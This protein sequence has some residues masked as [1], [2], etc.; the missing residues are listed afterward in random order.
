MSSKL[1]FQL[2]NPTGMINQVMSLE[3]AVGLSHETKKETIVHYISNQG[4]NLYNFKTVP[5][6]TPSRWYNEQRKGFTDNDQFP[7]I[8]DILE[9]D[10][11]I[12]LIDEKISKFP[13]EEL[14]ID[15]LITEGYFSKEDTISADEEQ[16]A[17]GRQRLDVTKNLHLK[18]TLGWY[19]RFFFNRSQSLDQ[20]LSSVKFKKE[21]FDFAE[22][23][24]KSIGEFQ[25]GHIRLSDHLHMFNTTQ[26]M[27]EAG[28]AELEQNRLPIVISTCDPNNAMIQKNKHRFILLDEYIVNNFSKEFLSL[29]FKDEVVFG[30]ICNIVM[31][32]AKY[33]IGTSGSTYTAYIQRQRNQNNEI[34]NWSFWDKPS[35]YYDGPFSWNNYNLENGRKM[36]WREWRESKL[37]I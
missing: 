10:A 16:F 24:C 32:K 35:D 37:N 34:E 22:M 36:W 11:D 28:L 21:Y 18:N 7:H 5:I 19:S 17:E 8:S 27:F 15:S 12:T 20:C 4:D 29:K 25:G 1:F 13:Q 31:Q 26:E 6:Y 9:W 2:H 3:L 30:L 33:F 23:I 14:V